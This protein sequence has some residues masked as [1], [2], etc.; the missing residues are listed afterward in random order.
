MLNKSGLTYLINYHRVIGNI[1][2]VYE[3][4]QKCS[5]WKKVL[6]T[7]W[8]IFLTMIILYTIFM[9]A[10]DIT[11]KQL[12]YSE[13]EVNTPSKRNLLLV[14]NNMGFFGFSFQ[15]LISII[16]LIVKGNRLLDHLENSNQDYINLKTERRIGL[17]LVVVQFLYA[18]SS[19]LF[20]YLMQNIN[21][22]KNPFKN[23]TKLIRDVFRY[24]LLF[25]TQLTVLSL[26]A[27]KSLIFSNE[28]KC[29]TKNNCKSRI[30]FKQIYTF[31]TNIHKSIKAFDKLIN[32]YIFIT[33]IIQTASCL[34]MST[35]AKNPSKYL[36]LGSAALL[37]SMAF[38]MALC[39]ICDRVSKS[40]VEFL[41][42]LNDKLLGVYCNPENFCEYNLFINRLV[43]LKSE[44][45]FT[46]CNLYVINTKTFIT[47]ILFCLSYIVII[48][49]TNV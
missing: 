26:I 44:M 43:E 9:T 4:N 17:T 7:T 40:Y 16:F 12:L 37:E 46:A 38:L 35:L 25:N 21:R 36:V 19:E 42:K 22:S 49:Q 11:I 30:D 23:I 33:I 28:F 5:I 2:L 14:I 1:S 29:F 8:N 24:S 41:D 34:S 31:V 47:C 45:C 18:F 6:L 39:L 20:V 48:I 27:Y 32:G 3:I 15:S 13:Q 10:L